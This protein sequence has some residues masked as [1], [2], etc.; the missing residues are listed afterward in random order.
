MKCL[1]STLI[2][3]P[4]VGALLLAF[5]PRLSPKASR[6]LALLFSL[7]TLGFAALAWSGFDPSGSY[8]FVE[9]HAWI[10][11]LNVSYHLGLDGMSLV[12]VLLTGLI[13]P[14]AL[15]ASWKVERDPRLFNLLFLFLQGAALGVFLALNFFPWFIFWEL[16]LVPAFFLI[17]L[18]GGP[19]ASRA[20]Y[21]FVVYTI[22]GSAFMLLGFAALFASTGTFDFVELAALARNGGLTAAITGP[23]LTAIFL[24]VLLGLAV[25]VPL[26]PF[27]TWL[28]SAYSEAPTGASM[29]L[30]GVM[31]K[32]GVYGF[33]RILWPLFPAQLHAAAPVLV[34]LA[35]AGVV[36]GTFAAMAQRDLKRMVA[37]SS[38]NHVSYCLLAL[39]AVAATGSLHTA[40]SVSALSGSLLQMFNHG[41]SAS[42]LFF[43]VGILE[44]RSGGKHGLNDFGG[45]R[46]SAPIFAGLCG[47]ALFSSL[48]LPGLN[49]FV[50]EF[51]VFR[52]VFGLVP[53]A[54][55]VGCLGLFATAYFL[56][57]FWQRV[58][59]GPQGPGVAAFRDLSALEVVTL[60]PSVVLM[61]V[62][63]IWP[64]LL[65]SVFNP[66]VTAWAR[67][68][69]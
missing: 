37:Y 46:T 55:A 30:T 16:S 64:Q 29:F 12:M 40:A 20:A 11:G 44:S 62:L 58:F 69:P 1:L 52:G 9:Q 43:C 36:L 6:I 61:F 15:L 21:Q 65:V 17:K 54:A 19:G 28:P 7:S 50:G 8:Q 26:F 59:H 33:L 63:G 5:T 67:H 51:L 48:G 18:W 68:L 31:S 34:G 39:F 56:L 10:S 57:T 4:W 27:H 47:V 24:G 32:M 2:L 14:I 60:V 23:V 66:L 42:A 35:L 13:A 38:I 25:K 53:W 45:V 41:L 49:G 22:G 3:T